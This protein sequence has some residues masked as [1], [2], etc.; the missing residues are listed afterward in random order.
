[1]KYLQP[2][3]LLA[4]VLGAAFV[5]PAQADDAKHKKHHDAKKAHEKT[6]AQ[7]AAE[8]KLVE[9]R[10][11]LK[12]ESVYKL[13]VD[14]STLPRFSRDDVA[15]QLER[16]KINHDAG[17]SGKVGGSGN[18]PVSDDPE[19]LKSCEGGR[20]NVKGAIKDIAFLLEVAKSRSAIL[21]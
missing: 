21:K 11:Q 16:I 20:T 1:M 9:C 19:L 4:F 2:S 7:L 13:P 8:A 15:K 10:E 6:P 3:I 17:L 5:L 18:G 14:L 12:T